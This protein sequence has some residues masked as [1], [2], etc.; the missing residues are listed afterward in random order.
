MRQLL[1]DEPYAIET[2]ADGQEAL[3]AVA[4]QQPDV[5]LLDLLMPHLDGFGVLAHLQ[6]DPRYHDMPVIVLTAK[7]LTSEEQTRLQQRVLT[8]MQKGGLERDGLIQEVRSALQAY[9]RP[10]P[11][12]PGPVRGRP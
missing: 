8:V 2:V 9:R 3:Q 7:T 4:R 6:Q 10:A 12:E 11:T 5:M 1:Q